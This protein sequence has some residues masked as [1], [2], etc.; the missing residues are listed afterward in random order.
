MDDV[1]WAQQGE[2]FHKV[3]LSILVAKVG[4]VGL[5][6]ANL[7]NWEDCIVVHMESSWE[8]VEEVPGSSFEVLVAMVS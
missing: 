3:A 6:E 7:A 5:T 4:L 1:A 2:N 8:K